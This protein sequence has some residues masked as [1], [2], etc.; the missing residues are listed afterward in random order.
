MW[1]LY[2]NAIPVADNL[3][4]RGCV[5]DSRCIVCGYD[6]ESAVLL[7]IECWWAAE[8]W[9]GLLR[10][11]RF[12]EFRFTSLS[13]WIWHCLQD[14]EG[15]DLTYFF[16]GVRFIWWNRNKLWHQETGVDIITAVA[17]VKRMAK[18]FSNLGYRFVVS[19]PEAGLHWTPPEAG[20]YKLS[21]DG[22]WNPLTKAGGIGVICHNHEGTVEFVYAEHM[23]IQG[24]ALEAE[25]VALKRGMELAARMG[26][27][28]ATFV[29]DN[30]E[31]VQ[32]LIR[33][34]GSLE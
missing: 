22:A 13:D 16:C 26:F 27:S 12:L 2:H 4:K 21:C 31:A 18:E 30:A 1:K 23:V 11:H 7:F 28:R 14:Y 34:V 25:G 9:R 15:E 17:M 5:V 29:S 6:V 32:L 20:S 24:S 3:I 33:N 19:G 8:L 10:S